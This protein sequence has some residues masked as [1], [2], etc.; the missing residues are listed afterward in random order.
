[1]PGY[2]LYFNVISTVV[3]STARVD[4]ILY[5]NVMS[6][7]QG[8]LIDCWSG[9]IEVFSLEKSTACDI[10]PAGLRQFVTR[11]GRI[12]IQRLTY[13]RVNNDSV[14]VEKRCKQTKKTKKQN[15]RLGGRERESCKVTE[16][17]LKK[18][19]DRDR[20]RQRERQTDRQRQRIVKLRQ[21]CCAHSCQIHVSGGTD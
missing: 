13:D 14:L 16:I 21:F 18:E 9:S 7:V 5:F 17:M 10:S 20:E 3:Q 4:Y 8:H 1:M 15:T 19:R 12:S 2:F 11:A 6:T